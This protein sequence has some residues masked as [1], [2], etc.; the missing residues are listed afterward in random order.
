[1]P[2]SAFTSRRQTCSTPRPRGQ[3]MPMP[4]TT[5]RRM[6]ASFSRVPVNGL[7]ILLFD[8]VDRV[9]DGGD[10]LRGVFGD[11]NAQGLLESHHQ[12]DRIAAIAAQIVDERDFRPA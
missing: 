9:L 2:V 5:T 8:V 12:F 6:A 7:L 10:L 1:M 3:T 4:V 11:F